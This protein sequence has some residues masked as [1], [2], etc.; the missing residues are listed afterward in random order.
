M[1]IFS[2][3]NSDDIYEMIVRAARGS[4]VV[5]DFSKDPSDLP[6]RPEEYALVF[7]EVSLADDGIMAAV[8]KLL[9]NSPALSVIFL[10]RECSFEYSMR[11]MRM[12]VKNILFGEEVNQT[13]LSCIIEDY[14]SHTDESQYRR[15]NVNR[16]FEKLIFFQD[17]RI[18][19]KNAERLNR[20]FS[21][22]GGGKSFFIAAVVS[23]EFMIR[24]SL[25]SS[26]Q[27][28]IE[29]E[30]MC[31]ALSGFSGD[32]FEACFAFYLDDVFYLVLTLP[33]HP[34]VKYMEEREKEVLARLRRHSERLLNGKTVCLASRCRLDF[35]GTE[36]ALE[37]LNVL[38]NAFHLFGES[39][40]VLYSDYYVR[41]HSGASYDKMIETAVKMLD[42]IGKNGNYREYEDKIFAI[43]L[44]AGLSYKQFRKFQEYLRFE[45]EFL[46]KKVD[47]AERRE[48][49]GL[50]SE[51]VQPINF[52]ALKGKA[53]ALAEYVTGQ[54]KNRYNY[55]ITRCLQYIADNYMTNIGLY[56]T[57]RH[58]NISTVYLSQLFKKE[59]G[60]NFNTYLN[61]YRME[62]ARA[63]IEN[64]NYKL[65]EICEMVGFNNMQYFS[66]YFKKTYG[67]TPNEY[68]NS[69]GGGPGKS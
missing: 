13:A 50:L 64:G 65:S 66:K 6:A 9:E 23:G 25:I 21:L 34:S 57:A 11:A 46:K 51:L 63:L 19:E 49:D 29:Y 47:P 62:K 37:E 38:L 69:G 42:E 59:V 53:H 10:M 56:E 58:L 39:Q 52:C 30:K 27:K 24:L 31:G 15:E 26:L 28:K 20:L 40:I 14:K 48:Y 22:C 35:R 67:K 55:L 16:L 45:F 8:K 44:M 12:G 32:D 60:K 2:Y 61:A 68:R 43:D 3:I 17:D 5:A 33:H 7:A 1:K 54:N 41:E 18:N 4:G 36:E